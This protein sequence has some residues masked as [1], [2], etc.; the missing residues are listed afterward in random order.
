MSKK[1]IKGALSVLERVKISQ[2]MAD[3]IST[4]VLKTGS[5]RSQIIRQALTHYMTH[6][7]SRVLTELESLKTMSIELNQR[8]VAMGLYEQSRFDQLLKALKAYRKPAQ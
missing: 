1:Q 3:F 6:E 5:S 7:E 8:L 4:E 2:D